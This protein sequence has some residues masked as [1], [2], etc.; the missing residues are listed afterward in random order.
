[1][2]VSTKKSSSQS[3]RERQLATSAAVKSVSEST[4]QATPSPQATPSFSITNSNIPIASCSQIVTTSL[5]TSTITSTFR[6]FY[7]E[8]LGD[9]TDIEKG[10]FPAF[11]RPSVIPAE[12]IKD[13]PHP[14][15]AQEYSI[16]E[17]YISENTRKILQN[18]S[19]LP[20]KSQSFSSTQIAS[21]AGEKHFCCGC[22]KKRKDIP[23]LIA[24]IWRFH[25]IA[26]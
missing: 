6:P 23:P 7:F 10:D 11:G 3:A 26:K 16:N 18:A 4:S 14:I 22:S 17:K 19:T 2:L 12:K 9:W 24:D 8:K 1:M 20:V 5:S 13:P 15:K 21:Y 25:P